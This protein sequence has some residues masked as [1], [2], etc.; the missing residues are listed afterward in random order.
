MLYVF[1][2]EQQDSG[3]SK[4]SRDSSN[5]WTVLSDHMKY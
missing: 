4:S 3:R 1:S 2:L 5:T